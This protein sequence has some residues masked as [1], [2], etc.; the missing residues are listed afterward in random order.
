MLEDIETVNWFMVS[1]KRHICV[2]RLVAACAQRM[3]LESSTR[4]S[5][6]TSLA[7]ARGRLASRWRLLPASP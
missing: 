6:R 5:Q 2:G 4:L 7:V 1:K 3:L